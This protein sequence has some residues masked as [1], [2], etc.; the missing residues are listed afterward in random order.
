MRT[1]SQDDE[2]V[3]R[4]ANPRTGI[5]SPFVSGRIVGE[6]KGIDYLTAGGHGSSREGSGASTHGHKILESSAKS[7]A[8]K[9]PELKS[10][11]SSATKLAFSQH[12]IPRKAIGSEPSP[13]SQGFR[14]LKNRLAANL[15]QNSQQPRE[16]VQE[17]LLNKDGVANLILGE[18]SKPLHDQSPKLSSCRQPAE[19]FPP[20]LK[21][22]RGPRPRPADHT[23]SWVDRKNRLRPRTQRQCGI[24]CLPRSPAHL[25]TSVIKNLLVENRG[26]DYLALVPPSCRCCRCRESTT[27]LSGL[28][29]GKEGKFI[30]DQKHVHNVDFSTVEEM[31]LEPHQILNDEQVAKV[32]DTLSTF[33]RL[34]EL[35]SLFSAADQKIQRVSPF[36]NLTWIRQRVLVMVIHVFTTLRYASPAL[37]VL[38]SS[39][40]SI[41][42]Y[43]KALRDFCRAIVY[44]LVLLNL[45]LCV[46]RAIRLIFSILA[47]IVWPIKL[48]WLVS[49]WVLH[50]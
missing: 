28:R 24:S 39:N 31:A 44:M 6:E 20:Q 13:R 32:G 2:L 29:I 10:D 42:D 30:D 12:K 3:Q 4:A 27:S 22:L 34:A 8:K 1:V 21:T 33:P 36:V 15:R 40:A 23:A 45:L 5:I 35:S 7:I 26:S 46:M 43:C 9:R 18:H 49:R 37:Q 17:R 38:K 11:K 47:A 48:L 14:G 25:E 16:L 19:L 50:G 41:G